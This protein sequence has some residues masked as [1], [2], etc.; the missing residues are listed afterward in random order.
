MSQNTVINKENNFAILHFLGA[1]LVVYGHQHYLL[2]GN[3]PGLLGNPVSTLGVKMI[4]VITGFLITQSFLR[5]QK[6]GEF[7]LRRLIRIY[8]ALTACV[9][10][11]AGGLFVL[12][13]TDLSTY[14]SGAWYYV[15]NNLALSP[16]YAL[17]GVFTQNPYPNAVN[18]S[19][20]TIPV[21]VA[22]YFVI[23]ILLWCMCKGQE[24]TKRNKPWVIAYT[25]IVLAVVALE[26]IK[27]VRGEPMRLVFWGTDWC[28]AMDVLPYMLIGSLFVVADLKKYCNLQVAFLLLLSAACI[29]WRNMELLTFIVVPYCT[30]SFALC[31][32]PYFSGWFER[33]NIAY[34]VFLWGFPIQQVIIYLLVARRH[35]PLTANTLF[36]LSLLPTMLMAYLSHRFVEVPVEG[37]LKKKLIKK[38]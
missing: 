4:F 16:Y 15:R 12:S 36:L 25:V 10:L 7:L 20:W 21:E 1:C 11:C 38:H 5:S 23:G 17:P 34:G 33:N 19:L 22:M 2:G 28:S 31:E 24:K 30:M 32:K 29:G 6:L 27:D 37:F 26:A 18:G 9:V 3:P 13:Y 8:P 14:L 35:M